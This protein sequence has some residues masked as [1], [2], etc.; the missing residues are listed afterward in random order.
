MHV[1]WDLYSYRGDYL[2]CAVR[3][4]CYLSFFLFLISFGFLLFLELK[5]GP[6]RVG[7]AWREVYVR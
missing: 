5:R 7:S 3:N 4:M 1:N 6:L 2:V